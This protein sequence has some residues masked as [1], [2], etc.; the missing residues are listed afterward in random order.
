MFILDILNVAICYK[1]Y[2]G[3]FK[4][5]KNISSSKLKTNGKIK[6]E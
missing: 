3:L 4:N 1:S 5:I 6:F 2:P